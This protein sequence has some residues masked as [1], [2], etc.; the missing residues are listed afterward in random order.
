MK[1][2]AL[3]PRRRALFLFTL[4]FSFSFAVYA[5]DANQSLGD[6][7]R[8]LRAKK[9]AQADAQEIEGLK[10]GD[11]RANVL[12]AESHDAIAKW[13]LTPAAERQGAARLREVPAGKKFY[14]PVVV[15][16]YPYPAS[17]KMKLTA[18]IRIISPDGRTVFDSP[19]F[20]SSIRPDPRSPNTIVLNP[21]MDMVFDSGDVPGTWTIRVTITDHVHSSYAKAEEQL[22]LIQVFK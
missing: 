2:I 7:A 12:I 4:I 13:V 20:S 10:E 16:D 22:Q 8:Q 21:V 6:Y 17:E 14:L 15:S 18:H 11:F 9:A 5:Q 1:E 3:K 19:S